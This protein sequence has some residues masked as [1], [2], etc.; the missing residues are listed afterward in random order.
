V[1]TY[2]LKIVNGGEDTYQLFS[3]GH[4]DPIEFMR[5]AKK[6]YPTWPMGHP[7]HEWAVRAP[8]AGYRYVLHPCSETHPKAIP[9]T[10]SVEAYGDEEWK[11]D[12]R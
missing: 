1:K 12:A 6:A 8:K 9:I 10:T 2:P 4:H 5:A 3:F 11:D 7:K